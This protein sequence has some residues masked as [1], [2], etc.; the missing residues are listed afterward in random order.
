MEPD[1]ITPYYG[2]AKELSIQ[3]VVAYSPAEFAAA[4]SAIA[5]GT[6]M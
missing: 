6:W 3:F 5:G 2:V 4:L 1:A